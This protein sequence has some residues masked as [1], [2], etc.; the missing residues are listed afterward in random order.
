MLKAGA[1]VVAFEPAP[2]ALLELRARCSRNQAWTLVPA[3]VGSQPG[4]AKLNCRQDSAKSSLLDD[5]IGDV[6][7]TEYVPVVT[8]DNAIN[9]F[10]KPFY[11]KIDVEG[12]ELEVL[13][14]LTHPIAL[15]SFEFHLNERDISK[16]LLCLK[17]LIGLGQ[18][19]VNITPAESLFFHFP[20]WIPL[21][22]F[23]EW[24][25]GDLKNKLPGDSYGDIFVKN[26]RQVSE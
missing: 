26:M 4:I 23:I 19:L 1:S 2:E 5:W 12:W 25:P 18:N 21:E 22:K 24:F 13:R 6:V 20:E 9:T 7:S 11:C 17:Q 15:L 14:G 8:L 10:G 3:A 16:T